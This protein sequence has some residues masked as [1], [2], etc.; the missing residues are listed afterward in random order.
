MLED[1]LRAYALD[2][3]GKWDEHLPLVEFVYNNSYQATIGMPPY[4]ALYGRKC[5]SPLY[6]DEVGEKAVVGPDLVADA[7]EKVKGIRQR[8]K[9]AQ[10]RYKS[11]TDKRRRPL[12]FRMG[13]HV[14]L[15]VSPTKGVIRFGVR[16]KLN[17]R[18]IGPFE[19]LERIG[20]VA[21]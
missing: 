6:W 19:V 3:E 14:F 8:M 13:D 7:V 9:A 21:Y 18:Y 5:R 17:P 1:M 4:E 16:G 15:K 11:Y 20:P 12:E 2:L 10:D